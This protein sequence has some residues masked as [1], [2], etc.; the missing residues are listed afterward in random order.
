MLYVAIKIKSMIKRWSERSGISVMRKYSK[1]AVALGL[2]VSMAV[3]VIPTQ[4]FAAEAASGRNLTVSGAFLILQI[5]CSN[6]PELLELM[7]CGAVML[8]LH[9]CREDGFSE[10]SLKCVERIKSLSAHF[11]AAVLLSNMGINLLQLLLAKWIYSSNY[12]IV[13]P[14]KEVLVLLGILMLSRFYLESRQLK[15]DNELF[16]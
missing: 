1:R 8:L 10:K 3:S 14:L 2:L 11:L 9:S 5:L 15:Q 6:L 7:L 16:I 4:S 12:S 13:F